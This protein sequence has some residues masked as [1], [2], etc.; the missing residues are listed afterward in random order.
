[1]LYIQQPAGDRARSRK[2]F[3]NG[4]RGLATKDAGRGF[5]TAICSGGLLAL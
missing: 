5:T 2:V 4:K 1:M 3:G